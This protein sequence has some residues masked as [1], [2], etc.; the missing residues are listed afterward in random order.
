MKWYN[1]LRERFVASVNH[2]MTLSFHTK[3]TYNHALKSSSILKASSH[4]TL[5]VLYVAN[6]LVTYTQLPCYLN[7]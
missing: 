4:M 5:S 2:D 7:T 6:Q 3:N 1:I